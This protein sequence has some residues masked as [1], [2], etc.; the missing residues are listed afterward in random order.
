MAI[1]LTLLVPLLSCIASAVFAGSILGRDS[2]N[3]VHRIAAFLVV[4]TGFWAF[5]E[6]LA[7]GQSDPAVVLAWVRA[8]ALGWVWIWIAFET[9]FDPRFFIMCE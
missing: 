3:R 4:G 1:S 5:C 6:V 9:G 2:S 7:Q 8:S